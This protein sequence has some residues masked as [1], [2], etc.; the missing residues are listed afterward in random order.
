MLTTKFSDQ[1]SVGLVGEAPHL[2]HRHRPAAHHVP[3]TVRGEVVQDGPR[4]GTVVYPVYLTLYIRMGKI[5]LLN[6]LNISFNV[7]C[8]LLL[9][10]S[11]KTIWNTCDCVPQVLSILNPWQYLEDC[12][13]LFYAFK[14]YSTVQYISKI[15]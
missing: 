10:I 13:T 9:G 14:D 6:N 1:V 4:E 8:S 3:D 12:V 15:L 7:S 11:A 5:E 2:L